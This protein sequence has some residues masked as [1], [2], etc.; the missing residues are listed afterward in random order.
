MIGGRSRTAPASS[1]TWPGTPRSP[2]DLARVETL[3]LAV[4]FAVF[5]AWLWWVWQE[6]EWAHWI[7]LVLIPL[8]LLWLMHRRTDPGFGPRD[9]LASVGLVRNHLRDGLLM[10]VVVALAMSALMLALNKGG[11]AEWLEVFRSGKGYWLLPLL[12]LLMLVTAATTEEFFFRGCI[13]RALTDA[14]GRPVL[15][16]VVTAL[17]FGLYHVPYRYLDSHDLGQAF[18]QA[19]VDALLSGVVLGVVYWRSRGNLLAPILTH[20]VFNAVGGLAMVHIGW[21]G[22]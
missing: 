14:T 20:A 19:M 18:G 6:P 2:R 22:I 13:Q 10:A 1:G 7:T 12:V 16:V 11:F 3:V 17:L 15:A 4:Y 8:G 21:L 9:A 5:W